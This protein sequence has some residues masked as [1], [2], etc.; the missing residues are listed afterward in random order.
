[1]TNNEPDKTIND[2][3]NSRNE[4]ILILAP[5]G[6]DAEMTARVLTEAGLKP[7][8]CQEIR[9]L[10]GEMLANAGL[11]FLT[12]EALTPETTSDLITAL[13]SQ[14]PWSDIPLV[15]LT[16]GGGENPANIEALQLLSEAGNVTLVERP[17]RLMTLM[18]AVKSA[19]RARRRQY[20]ARDYLIAEIKSREA[21]EESEERLNIALDAARLGAWEL[22]LK[23]GEL[24]CTAN[25]KANFGLP[26]EADFSYP[27]LLAMIHPHDRETVEKAVERAL[28]E[29][30]EYKAEYRIFWKDGTFRW[31]QANG[32][33]NYDANGAP[34]NMI[35]V[36]LDISERKFAERERENLLIRERAARA[37]AEAANR[38]KDEFLATVS[39]ELR[40]P[41]NAMLGWTNL[42]RTGR[43][44]NQMIPQALA[45]VER[46]ARSQAQ[47]IEDLLDVSRIITG[48]LKLDVQPLDA[49]ALLKS[50]VDSISPAAGAKN[51][52]IE[53]DIANETGKIVG[54][55]ARL[56]QVLWNLL[57]N[58]VKFTPEGGSVKVG[59]KRDSSHLLISVADTG[60]GIA[61]EFLPFVFD[62]F[63]QADGSTTRNVGG[64]GLGLAIV[65]HL[66]E[67]H[68]GTVQAESEGNG[69]GSTFTVRLPLLSAAQSNG[70]QPAYTANGKES[71]TSAGEKSLAGIN[72][73]VVDDEI[74]TLELIKIFL[75][76]SGAQVVMAQS[77]AEALEKIKLSA[78]D[79]IVSDIGMPGT[80]GYEFIENVRRLAP[81]KGGDIPAIALTAYARNEDRAEA[82]RCG[83]QTHV[84]KPVEMSELITTVASLAH[85]TSEG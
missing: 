11:L 79:V 74:D 1:M 25:C 2:L 67:Q 66:V 75:E 26:P 48:K 29:K 35:G 18:S 22:D 32:R 80:S 39:H 8:V 54:D 36:T 51:I 20:D 40:T 61:P 76:T 15:V 60:S 10:C 43:L 65:R 16:S 23:T 19:L 45:T 84:A 63:R 37:E 34:E 85:Y 78:P 52:K 50:A 56:Q 9:E 83:F 38:L 3:S 58:A 27:E 31:I 72:V 33:A 42:L 59:L 77:V 68:G 13:S 41:L 49:A 53:T 47:I 73:L 21:L 55:S 44:D 14:P 57:S 71:S 5:T 12:G 81:E 70:N 30:V 69:K 6:R 82:L 4:T 28:R 7:K 62:R 46:N 24:N 17:V 64:L